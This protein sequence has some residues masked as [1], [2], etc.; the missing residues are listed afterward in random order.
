MCDHVFVYE[1][2]KHSNVEKRY[3]L[4]G[5][6]QEDR[7]LFIVFTI[8]NNRVRVVSA[9]AMSRVERKFYETEEN[10]TDS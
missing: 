3:Y 8:R 1:D 9:R 5:K 4:L 6:T 7:K 10:K 2:E